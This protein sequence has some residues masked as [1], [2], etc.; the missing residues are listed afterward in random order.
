MKRYLAL[1]LIL[2]SSTAVAGEFN[3]EHKVNIRGY[4]GFM[5]THKK[6]SHNN[7][8]N[9]LAQRSDA[10]L[11]AEYAFND[12]YKISWNNSSSLIFRQHDTRYNHDGEWRFYNWGTFKTPYGRLTAGQEFNVAYLFHQGAQDCGPLDITDTSLTW[13][14][15]NH[16]WK[17]GKKSVGFLTPKSTAMLTD[18]RALKINYVAPKIYNTL[19]GFTYTPDS[20]SR[21]GLTSRYNNYERDDAYVFGMHNEWEFDFADIYTSAGYGL[22]NRTDKE[23]TLG[24]TLARGGWTYAAGYRKSY[25]DGN[26]NPITTVTTDPRRPAFYDNYRE[27]QS[28][29]LSIGYE[30]GPYKTTLAYLHTK[31]DNTPNKDDIILW[32]NKYAYT[33]WLDFYVIGGYINSR[34]I[35]KQDANRN[36]GYAG[37]VGVGINF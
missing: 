22:F 25:V 3:F 36:S 27:S 1:S 8:P 37:I 31:A 9:R 13:F 2:F 5:D 16:N 34:G 26:K 29:D 33:K 4:Y 28:W 18:G 17:N 21:R 35:N 19:L 11:K 30:V 7:L 12:D 23:L 14:L 32:S 20:P 24:I 10:K 15:S 6:D